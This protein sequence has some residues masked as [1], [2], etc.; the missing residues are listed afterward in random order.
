[1][2]EV[3][4]ITLVFTQ[5]HGER[6]GKEL[7]IDPTAVEFNFDSV[8]ASLGVDVSTNSLTYR[9]LQKRRELIQKRMRDYVVS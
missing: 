3:A 8:K 6:L 4:N 1:L 5:R 7:G 9:E 2:A